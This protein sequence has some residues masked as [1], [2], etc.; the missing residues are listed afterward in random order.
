MTKSKIQ[1]MIYDSFF[2]EIIDNDLEMNVLKIIFEDKCIKLFYK[3]HSQGLKT[4]LNHIVCALNKIGF[5]Y[6]N[7]YCEDIKK[8]LNKES[9]N[10]VSYDGDY[11]VDCYFDM[12]NRISTFFIQLNRWLK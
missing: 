7:G 9:A 2:E 8:E 12:E 6:L 10:I 5:I 1:T 4:S 3:E 11:I